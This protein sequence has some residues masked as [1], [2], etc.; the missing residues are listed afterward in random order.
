MDERP[1]PDSTLIPKRREE[2][3]SPP[4]RALRLP[5]ATEAGPEAVAARRAALEQAG[6]S[7]RELAGEGPGIAPEELSGSVEGFVGFARVPVGVFGPLR[8]DGREARGEFVVPIATTEGALV[9]SFQH[10]ANVLNRAGGVA[11][12][13][14][15]ERVWR[16]PAFAFAGLADA[17]RFAE[18]IPSQRVELERCVGGTSRHARLV[19]VVPRVVGSEVFL[20]LGFTTGDAA[21]QNMVTFAAEA[22]CRHLLDH[23]PTAPVQWLVEGN[24]SG[25]KKAT[26][27]SLTGVRGKRVSAEALVPDKLCR[28]YFRVGAAEMEAGWNMAATGATA[29]GAV[30]VQGN[31]ANALTGL[32][33]ACGQDVA[34]V[35]EAAVGIT[36][37][38]LDASGD[39]Q[40]S[41]TLPNV[42]VG[43]VGGGTYLPTA[44]ECLALLDCEGSGKARKLAEICAAVALAGE[45]ALLG[46]VVGGGFARAHAAFGRRPAS[47][48]APVPE[49]S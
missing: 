29:G 22:I 23:A 48:S 19:E 1:D 21:G 9:M 31:Y 40:L 8:I 45:L 17:V 24:H 28:R 6:C 33:L 11:A 3:A 18:W 2:A 7:T 42:I 34:C 26:F 46:A 36:R 5:S 20:R 35:A 39:L 4:G 15:D 10:A 49:R 32:F 47:G 41:V 25:D 43:T 16:A 37:A 44:R 13:C 38:R 12:A 14:T 30:G 27:E